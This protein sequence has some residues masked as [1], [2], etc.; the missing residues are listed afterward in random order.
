MH[1]YSSF[2]KNKTV[3]CESSKSFSFQCNQWVGVVIMGSG[4]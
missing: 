1:M 3:L 4:V 2:T